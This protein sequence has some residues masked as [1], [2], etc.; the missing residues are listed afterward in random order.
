[1]SANWTKMKLDWLVAVARDRRARGLPL[2]VMVVLICEYFNQQTK[3]AWPSVRRLARDLNTYPANIHRACQRLVEL[4][5]LLKRGGGGRGHS[6]RYSLPET[7]APTL[8][9]VSAQ[10]NKSVSAS[11]NRTRESTRD[12]TPLRRR[13]KS[14]RAAGPARAAPFPDKWVCGP[15]ELAAAAR[16]AAGWDPERARKEFRKFR[17]WHEDRGTRSPDWQ[18]TWQTWCEK[19]AEIDGRNRARTSTREDKVRAAARGAAGWFHR[20]QAAHEEDDAS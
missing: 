1:M 18:K 3:S 7:L 4:G 5:W 12:G 19:G 15:S 17:R 6:N 9:G 14:R 8:T 13:G 10:A 2:G 11:A 20:Q 16:S